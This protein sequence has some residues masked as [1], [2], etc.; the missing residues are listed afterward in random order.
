MK[1]MLNLE[2]YEM[3]TNT[4]VKRLNKMMAPKTRIEMPPRAGSVNGQ[5]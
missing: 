2:M 4:T 1:S 5:I 3:P